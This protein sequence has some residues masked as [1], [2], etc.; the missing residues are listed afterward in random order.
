[1]TYSPA[2]SNL[3]SLRAAYLESFVD[4]VKLQLSNQLSRSYAFVNP[5]SARYFG[6]NA[7]KLAEKTHNGNAL[8]V[9]KLNTAVS[10][11][12]IGAFDQAVAYYLQVYQYRQEENDSTGIS[13][14]LNNLGAAYASMGNSP[15]SLDIL[16]KSLELKRALGQSDRTVTTLANIGNIYL[17]QESY[18]QALSYYIQSLEISDELGNTRGSFRAN[19]NI[20]LTLLKL[21]NADSALYY[22]RQSEGLFDKSSPCE[23]IFTLDGL[24]QAYFDKEA[25]KES[26]VYAEDLLSIS[27]DCGEPEKETSALTILGKIELKKGAIRKGLSLL[28][29]AAKLAEEID[30]RQNIVEISF[31]L[32]NQYKSLGNY[33]DALKYLELY[34]Q[35]NDTLNN[36]SLTRELTK[37]SMQYAFDQ[38][39]DSIA[40]EQKLAETIYEQTLV[41]K[42]NSL[43]ILIGLLV[44]VL[45]VAVILYLYYQNKARLSLELRV[46]N[47][48]IK[49]AFEEREVL[50]R[51]IHHRVK[52][53]LQIVSSLLNIQSKLTPQ[54]DAKDALIESRDRV[55]TMAMIHQKLYRSEDLNDINLKDYIEEV[56]SAVIASHQ[57]DDKSIHLNLSIVDITLQLDQMINVGL[58]VNELITNALKHA[59]SEVNS[60][61]ISVVMQQTSTAEVL[62]E[63]SDDGRNARGKTD[64]SY[65]QRLIQSLVKGMKGEISIDTAIGTKTRI[66]FPIE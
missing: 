34:T 37:V 31:I 29:E 50:M 32:F 23:K 12:V 53:N 22:F 40:Y 26:K 13:A 24:S 6:L 43:Y 65:G 9:A 4:S 56:A 38:E 33:R 44:L 62:L 2:Q 28:E 64:S 15:K 27:R 52:N 63:V 7:I 54:D 47:D 11:H 25:L 10:Y 20:G 51:E 42:E 8:A 16:Q 14:V 35:N 41:K 59:F 19:N 3:D 48:K 30:Q 49:R 45:I 57:I 60:G 18:D 39:L 36:A 46:Q 5:D 66:N 55:L 21:N 17:E 61:N 58:I 1:V